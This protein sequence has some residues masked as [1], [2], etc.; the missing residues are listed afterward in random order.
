MKKLLI[1]PAIISLLIGVSADAVTDYSRETSETVLRQ[2]YSEQINTNRNNWNQ[3]ISS[4]EN[5]YND[6]MK[7]YWDEYTAAYQRQKKI[8][9]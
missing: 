2:Q 3:T 1:V 9:H 7:K 6:S 5:N 4:Y 8:Q